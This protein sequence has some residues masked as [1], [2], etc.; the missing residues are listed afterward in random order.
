MTK[1]GLLGAGRIGQVHA[2]AVSSVP[3]AQLVAVADPMPTAAEALRDT[4]GCE[5]RTIA[6]IRDS[7]DI[8]AVIICTPTD[9]HA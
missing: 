6:Q 1:I 2:R 9:T 3:S 4:Y 8:D 7:A 5:I